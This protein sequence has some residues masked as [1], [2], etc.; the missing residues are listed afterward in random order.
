ML[1]RQQR[2]SDPVK[3]R[4]TRL[5]VPCELEVRLA[6]TAEP[7]SRPGRRA[8]AWCRS[9]ILSRCPLLCCAC[10]QIS[11]G[12]LSR[13]SARNLL[14]CLPAGIG[15][16][17]RHVRHPVAAL[18][19]TFNRFADQIALDGGNVLRSSTGPYLIQA[20][21]LSRLKDLGDGDSGFK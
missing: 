15:R 1:P 11:S 21:R 9:F 19:R 5:A 12:S 13:G 17:E 4:V 16:F 3:D 14:T 6:H 7:E 18:Y 10:S 20:V 8:L 2:G